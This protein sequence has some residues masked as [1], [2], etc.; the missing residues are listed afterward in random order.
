LE[1]R[2]FKIWRGL[3]QLHKK[4]ISYRRPV[5]AILLAYEF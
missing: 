2:E 1:I 5:R 4:I 3:V